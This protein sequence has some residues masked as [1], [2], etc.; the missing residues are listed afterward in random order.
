MQRPLL[1]AS[2]ILECLAGTALL[3]F[4]GLSLVV[5]LGA[6]PDGVGLMVAR[7][8]GAALFALGI[9]CAGAATEAAR[10]TPAGILIAITFYNAV[11]GLLLLAFAVRGM[12]VGPVVWVAG[13]LHLGLAAGFGASTFALADPRVGSPQ[14][15]AGRS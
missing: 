14:T 2:V 5:L 13:A 8:A 15:T 4:P 3:L 6:A 1:F 10:G 9:A 7:V 12:A 11:A